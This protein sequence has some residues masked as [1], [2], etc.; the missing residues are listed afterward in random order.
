MTQGVS[1][2]GRASVS[3]SNVLQDPSFTQVCILLLTQEAPMRTLTLLPQMLLSS[4]FH[5][6]RP[7]AANES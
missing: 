3:T 6:E 4:Q 7:A 5:Q 1:R 2:I